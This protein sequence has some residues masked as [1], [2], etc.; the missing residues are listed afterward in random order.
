MQSPEK[1]VDRRSK[2]K[3]TLRQRVTTLEEGP[4]KGASAAKSAVRFLQNIQNYKV[5][6]RVRPKPG[7]TY[8]GLSEQFPKIVRIFLTWLCTGLR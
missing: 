4:K 5:S 1:V 7:P 3:T 8:Q 2:K 6:L